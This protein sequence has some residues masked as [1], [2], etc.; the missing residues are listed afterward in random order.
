MATLEQKKITHVL[1]LKSDASVARLWFIGTIEF[2][3]LTISLYWGWIIK[4]RLSETDYLELKKRLIQHG[5]LVFH[6][7]LN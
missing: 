1:A 7:D 5:V 6:W 2:A 4:I 3:G